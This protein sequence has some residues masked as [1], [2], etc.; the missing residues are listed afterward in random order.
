MPNVGRKNQPMIMMNRSLFQNLPNT[1]AKK[2]KKKPNRQKDERKNKHKQQSTS[3]VAR[4]A[5]QN[6]PPKPYEKR[7]EFPNMNTKVYGYR[8]C[9]SIKFQLLKN[10]HEENMRK[11]C[12]CCPTGCGCCP[13]GCGCCPTSCCQSEPS[14]MT[15]E[16]LE[17]VIEGVQQI[18]AE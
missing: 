14:K 2:V 5:A 16:I 7:A 18:V 4:T 15:Q 13:T 9:T 17:N 1:E 12:G 10:E 6:A 11:C 8:S 3:N